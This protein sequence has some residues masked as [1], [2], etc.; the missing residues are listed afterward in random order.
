[1]NK[2]VEGSY[3]TVEDAVHAVKALFTQGYAKEDLLIVT[4]D[5][6]K[7][8]LSDQTE[9][10]IT[11]DWSLNQDKRDSDESVMDKIKDTFTGDSD[12]SQENNILDDHQDELRRGNILVLAETT[13]EVDRDPTTDPNSDYDNHSSIEDPDVQSIPQTTDGFKKDNPGDIHID[14]SDISH[15]P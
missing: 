14:N 4:D 3:T 10:T 11:T 9:V 5:S 6:K 8:E 15:R 1:M 12:D 13:P 7:Q 2:Y